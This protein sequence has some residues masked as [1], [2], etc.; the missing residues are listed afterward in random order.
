M[1]ESSTDCKQQHESAIASSIHGQ[2]LVMCD[3]IVYFPH[4]SIASLL[5]PPDPKAMH[6]DDGS[7]L[8]TQDGKDVEIW[9]T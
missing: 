1:R 6:V 7:H 8:L 2:T 5:H 4:F 3:S 9:L